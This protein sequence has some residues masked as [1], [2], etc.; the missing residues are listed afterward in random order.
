MLQR[1]TQ[2]DFELRR[3]SA[4]LDDLNR[5]QEV[6]SVEHAWHCITDTAPFVDCLRT[7]SDE[8]NNAFHLVYS[9]AAAV[10]ACKVLGFRQDDLIATSDVLTGKNI[11]ATCHALWNLASAC[12]EQGVKV[13]MSTHPACPSPVVLGASHISMFSTQVD[14]S[15][16][17]LSA[18]WDSAQDTYVV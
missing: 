18:A 5:F 6:T 8:A 14:A 11:T 12:V 9:M 7:C 1:I 3:Y 16:Q 13:C 2:Q 15:H 4:M 10:Q 17:S